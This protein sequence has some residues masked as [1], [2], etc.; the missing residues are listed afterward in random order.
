[1]SA[2]G[3]LNGF[4][5]GTPW[6]VYA[7]SRDGAFL[8][9]LAKLHERARIPLRVIVLQAVFA[10]VYVF[11]ATLVQIVDGLVVI[12]W[13]FFGLAGCACWKLSRRAT[14]DERSRGAKIAVLFA[15]LSLF[16]VATVV[17]ASLASDKHQAK[18]ALVQLG[19]LGVGAV[20]YAVVYAV[21]RPKRITP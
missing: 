21:S 4:I 20:V 15:A 12:D 6:I 9:A 8:P 18:M 19:V 5:L 13:L 3:V 2:F 16:V 1:M 11:S 14:G 10:L 17:W 7:M